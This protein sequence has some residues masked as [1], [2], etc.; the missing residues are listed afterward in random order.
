M[1]DKIKVI[2]AKDADLI[3]IKEA[4][5]FYSEP[6]PPGN[7][8]V[9]YKG[10]E[11]KTT[12][13]ADGK[14]PVVRFTE[15]KTKEQKKPGPSEPGKVEEKVRTGLYITS[16]PDQERIYINKEPTDWRTPHTLKHASGIIVVGTESNIKGKVITIEEGKVTPV[17]ITAE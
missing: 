6:L 16:T 10:Q 7:Y 15:P 17:H 5:V 11:K 2:G 12:L 14:I 9:G 3:S 1:A 4:N 13:T 8:T